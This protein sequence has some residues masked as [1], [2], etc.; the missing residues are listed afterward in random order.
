MWVQNLGWEDPLEKGMATF[1]STLAWRIPWTDEIG[2][3]QSMGC[4]GLDKT[5]MTLHACSS[6]KTENAPVSY[7]LVSSLFCDS[8]P[9]LTFKPC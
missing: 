6:N 4:K 8:S 1:F 3:L 7:A 9:G 5:E 2:G